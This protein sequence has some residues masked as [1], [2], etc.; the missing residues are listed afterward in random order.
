MMRAAADG[1]RARDAHGLDHSSIQVALGAEVDT[2]PVRKG[3]DLHEFKPE[4]LA[5][6]RLTVSVLVI[7]AVCCAIAT[8]AAQ[9][10]PTACAAVCGGN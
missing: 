1:S 5:Y 4:W 9:P 7:A 6:N 8:A 10:R 2:D 3:I